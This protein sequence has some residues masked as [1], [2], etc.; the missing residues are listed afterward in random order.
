MT[1]HRNKRE[2]RPTSKQTTLIRKMTGSSCF[3]RSGD[4]DEENL[5][6]WNN[7]SI[8]GKFRGVRFHLQV[9]ILIFSEVSCMLTSFRN[10]YYDDFPVRCFS[11]HLKILGHEP[12][13]HSKLSVL[14]ALTVLLHNLPQ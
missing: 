8:K 12:F 14:L 6:L 5:V 13:A 7:N 11:T 2:R 1:W 9:G 3:L 10:C 4:G